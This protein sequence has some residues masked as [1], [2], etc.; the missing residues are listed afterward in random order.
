ML[1]VIKARRSPKKKQNKKRL[2]LTVEMVKQVK[3]KRR[4]AVV[5]IATV[6][7]PALFTDSQRAATTLREG[8]GH[9]ET[10]P[11]QAIARVDQKCTRST[12]TPYGYSTNT[13]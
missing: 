4:R 10:Q 9:A 13:W 12:S 1:V 7:A 8:R 3:T 11:G 5:A 2:L 6:G